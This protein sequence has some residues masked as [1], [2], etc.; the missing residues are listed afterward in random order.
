VAWCVL[1]ICRLHYLL[2]TG[3]MTS[4]SGAGR[5]GLAAFGPRW[6]PILAEALRA[7]EQPGELSEYADDPVARGRD[8]AAFTT[9][10]VESGLACGP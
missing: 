3:S 9:M 8:A 5:H 7:R 1:G 6:R 4:K 2:T 10:A